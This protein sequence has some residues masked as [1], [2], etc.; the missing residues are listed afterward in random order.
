M[1]QKE[2]K[3]IKANP[4]RSPRKSAKPHHWLYV[5]YSGTAASRSHRATVQFIFVSKK[6]SNYFKSL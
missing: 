1:I 3:K 6:G 5:V 2:S 4:K